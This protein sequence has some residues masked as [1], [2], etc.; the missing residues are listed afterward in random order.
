MNRYEVTGTYAVEV[1]VCVFAESEE[2]A[3][4]M[5]EDNLNVWESANGG[6]FADLDGDSDAVNLS[7]S[8][9][10]DVDGADLVE[11]DVEVDNE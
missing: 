7:A 10:V 4:N 3:I 1:S 8:N 2:E 11:E 9:E 6:I 5:V